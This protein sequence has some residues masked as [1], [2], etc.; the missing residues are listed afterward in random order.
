MTRK[1]ALS[2]TKKTRKKISTD[3]IGLISA[4]SSVASTGLYFFIYY[5]DSFRWSWRVI[6]FL[7][8]LVIFGIVAISTTLSY[9]FLKAKIFLRKQGINPGDLFS[10]AV[11]ISLGFFFLGCVF[12]G[13][14]VS[15]RMQAKEERKSTTLQSSAIDTKKETTI[16]AKDTTTGNDKADTNDAIEKEIPPPSL[17]Q[18]D[19]TLNFDIGRLHVS[20]KAVSWIDIFLFGILNFLVGGFFCLG[21]CCSMYLAWCGVF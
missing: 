21:V 7:V 18:V 3:I 20:L 12:L 10:G 8:F 5:Q 16:P 17:K 4:A 6:T 13:F 11:K 2:T 19:D 1:K 9:I 15:K 14:F